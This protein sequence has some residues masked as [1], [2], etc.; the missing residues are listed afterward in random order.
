MNPLYALRQFFILLVEKF[1]NHAKSVIGIVIFILFILGINFKPLELHLT[2]DQLINKDFQS[3]IDYFSLK[4]EFHLGK[5]ST[6]I[7]EKENGNFTDLDL[8]R[9]RSFSQQV[10]ITEPSFSNY[11]SPLYLRKTNFKMKNGSNYLNFPYLLNLNCDQATNTPTNLTNLYHTPWNDYLFSKDQKSFIHEFDMKTIEGSNFE[12]ETVPQ[13]AI[14][15]EKIFKPLS[16][17][18]NLHWIGDITYQRYFKEGLDFNNNLNILILVIIGIIFKIYFGTFVSTFIFVLTVIFSSFILFALMSL[19]HTPIDILNNCLILLLTVSSLG[20]FVFLSSKEMTNSNHWLES[21]KEII[22]PSFFTSFTT[23]IG[24]ISLYTSE[25]EVI[26]R[27]GIWGGISGLI[28]WFTVMIILPPFLKIFLKNRSWVQKNYQRN[29]LKIDQFI[30]P[31][32]SSRLS[33][34]L[35]LFVITIPF[36]I[37]HINVN[38]RPDQL[39]KKDNPF[40]NSIEYLSSHFGFIGDVSLVFNDKNVAN[41]NI[42]K[43]ELISKYSLVS[44]VE[45]PYHSLDYY[46]KE[47]PFKY[48][49][50]IQN[51]LKETLQFKRLFSDQKARA[52]VYLKDIDMK[53]VEHLRQYVRNQLCAD[54]SCYLSGSLIA[55]ADFSQKV[56]NTLI[57]SFVISLLLVFV[58]LLFLAYFTHNLKHIFKLSLTA[59]WGVAI[60][61]F[62]ISIFQIEMNFVTC[63]VI[64]ILVGMTGDNTIQYILAGMDSNLESGVSERSDASII[65]TATMIACSGIFLLYYFEPPKT[66]GLL[67]IIGL[68]TSLIGD[69][70]I[71]LGLFKKSPKNFSK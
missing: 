71:F 9:I 11:F 70:W 21:F 69:Y 34:I 46:T 30:N 24:F 36:S 14:V 61:L 45:N 31:K 58:I 16:Q 64:S 17:R 41:K 66:F 3:S 10:I 28:E 57:E 29:F 1:Y 4:K 25:I 47:T 32:L 56:P 5:S 67:L 51:N 15:I 42:S 54:Q 13:K 18:F 20:D 8:C 2:I 27:L 60:T 40:R 52:V 50:L 53:K 37:K 48:K 19:F 35:L 26:R 22:T 23:F 39:F 55:Y 12:I 44:K 38:D 65:N 63:V 7:I 49:D 59:F 33:K 68:L 62:I 6:V 43:I